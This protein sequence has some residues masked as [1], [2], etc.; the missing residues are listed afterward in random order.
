MHRTRVRVG[1]AC[2]C[3]AMTVLW[4]QEGWT[5][6][7]R[8]DQAEALLQSLQGRVAKDGQRTLNQILSR[9]TMLRGQLLDPAY[10]QDPT[11]EPP[12][13]DPLPPPDPP[14]P[15]DPPPPSGGAGN[16]YFN[17]LITRS[18]LHTAYAL[19]TQAE[20]DRYKFGLYAV[21][22][23]YD[24][25]ADAAKWSWGTNDLNAEQMRLPIALSRPATGSHKLLIISDHWWDEAWLTEWWYTRED[26]VL[27]RLE[28]WK[29]LQV[30]DNFRD[31]AV[32][33]HQ[34]IWFE[35]QMRWIGWDAPI[36]SW[37]GARG[38]S[39][40]NPPTVKGGSGVV[41]CGKNFLG[42]SLGPM[43]N[44]FTARANTW[45]R[46]FLEIEQRA[47]ND[48]AR[49][50]YWMA[51]ETQEAM[52][53]LLNAELFSGGTNLGFWIEY[54]TSRPNRVGGPMAAYAR[55]VVV[56]TDV[57]DPSPLLLRPVR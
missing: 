21:K 25:S 17:A 46:A 53:I 38:Y 27:T 28:G 32:P 23:N 44:C 29:W 20:I 40:V 15:D 19:R 55:N 41:I 56:L 51:D 5:D 12:P 34:G 4:A 7:Q 45:T 14:P 22:V 54:N 1:L 49:V 10:V 30:T 43:L 6:G 3:A 48:Y 13:P 18:D 9:V 50:S 42:D 37:F 52:P 11:P 39:A 31:V 16:D 36:L 2:V 57:A 8:L 35:P 33:T 47:G 24:A 26:G